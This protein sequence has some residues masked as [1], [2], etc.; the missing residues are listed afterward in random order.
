M[1]GTNIGIAIMIAPAAIKAT[2]G[3]PPSLIAPVPNLPAVRR[4]MGHLAGVKRAPHEK[5]AARYPQARNFSVDPFKYNC[6]RLA[7]TYNHR[8]SNFTARLY[9]PT[10][11]TCALQ[12]SA[13]GG[14]RTSP[15]IKSQLI[16]Q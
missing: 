4:A 12:M 3:L 14:K 15:L 2:T 10:A 5:I 11:A 7:V 1:P 8:T 13:F 6:M 9:R 16:T